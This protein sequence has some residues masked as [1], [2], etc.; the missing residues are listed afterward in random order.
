MDAK[1]TGPDGHLNVLVP[2]PDRAASA[3]PTRATRVATPAEP[4]QSCA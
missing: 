2:G 4:G 3:P 1:L